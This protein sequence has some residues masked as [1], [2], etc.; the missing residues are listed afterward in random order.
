MVSQSLAELES[1]LKRVD[2]LGA[3]VD[4]LSRG[5]RAVAREPAVT[6]ELDRLAAE[7]EAYRTGGD[8]A[9]LEGV[10]DQLARL[11]KR[12]RAEYTISVVSSAGERSA[13]KRAYTDAAGKRLSGY[14]LIVQA[15][16]ADGSPVNRRVHNSETGKDEEVRRWAERVPEEVYNRLAKDKK[17]DG[18]LN[19]TAFGAKRKGFLDEEVTIPGSDGRPL[20]RT[21]QITT[22]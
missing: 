14:Y 20:T 6:T 12:V 1:E 17:E 19:E 21:A 9:R 22:W 4:T 8:P 13:I 7:A 3:E 10:R 11:E 16:D 18:I 15:K 2:D 5:M